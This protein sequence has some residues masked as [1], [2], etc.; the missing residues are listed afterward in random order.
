MGWNRRPRASYAE[1][2]Q[3]P[4]RRLF[5]ATVETLPQPYQILGIVEARMA[6]PV[7]IVPATHLLAPLEGEAEALGADGVIGIQ[8]NH[9]VLPGSSGIGLL[10]SRV[11]HNST[12]VA[13]AIGTAV[14]VLPSARSGSGHPRPSSRSH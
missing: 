5:M 3:P 8:V 9:V 6:A 7:G 4:R 13:T 2:P 14:R 10:G 1:E 11:H 12:V